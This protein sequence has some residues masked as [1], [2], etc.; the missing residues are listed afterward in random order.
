M[1]NF[2]TLFDSN[3]FSRG[4]ALYRSLEAVCGD[5]HLFIFAFDDTTDSV[6]RKLNL[7]K[8]S[9][10]S[11]KQ[12]EDA[13]LLQVKPSRS[14]AEYCWTATSST[15]LY[16][17]EKYNVD[18]CTYLDADMMFFDSPK[19]LFDEIGEASILITEHRYTKRYNKE[20]K[21]G[22]Y[23]V[24][25]VSFRNDERGLKALR[26]WR[27]RCLEWCYARTED[28]KF[29]D[30][31]Y[32]DDWTTR[33][34][35]VH[36]LQHLGGGMAAWNVQQYDVFEKNG[37]LLGREKISGSEFPIILYHFHYLRFLAGNRVELGRRIL[38]DEVLHS[39][40]S[41]YLKKLERAKKEIAV[42]D[43]SFDPHG[44]GDLDINWK[45]PLL[46]LYRKAFG[47]Y[48]IYLEAKLLVH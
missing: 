42:I 5:F 7:P 26:W 24:Q 17:L 45:T 37:K 47:I 18:M 1:Y 28:G 27:E 25:F 39:L 12:F 35:G 8:A 15:I 2:C 40:Y 48:H 34:E 44:R 6:L 9:I 10:I 20:A 23:C 32:L 33:F 14:R 13:E 38:S 4:L 21:S 30:Q 19:T 29:G 3:Y 16:V 22:I 43:A 31:K 46:Y 41:P 11:L 36:V